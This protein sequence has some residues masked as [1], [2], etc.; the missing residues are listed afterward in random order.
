MNTSK[1]FA[2]LVFALTVA[3]ASTVLP[4]SAHATPPIQAA[5]FGSAGKGTIG[6]GLL[7]AELGF[8]IPAILK[9]N[10]LWVYCTFPAVGAAGGALAGYF[11]FD[12]PGHQPGGVVALAIGLAGVIPTVVLMANA[13]RYDPDRDEAL[14]SSEG[15]RDGAEG[16]DLGEIEETA[17]THATPPGAPQGPTSAREQLRR[18]PYALGTGLFRLAPQGAFFAVPFMQ[19]TLAYSTEE[20]RAMGLSLRDNRSEF[21]VSVFSAVF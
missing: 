3:F 7:G 14:P 13:L 8:S 4:A 15:E 11:L 12:Q 2:P 21:H 10:E 6:F 5:T 1:I 17:P 18:D 16:D 20:M 19:T 9:R